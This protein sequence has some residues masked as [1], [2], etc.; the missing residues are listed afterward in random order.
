MYR[1]ELFVVAQTRLFKYFTQSL[2]F[3]LFLV[4]IH[5][6][7][8][9]HVQQPVY[10]G[11]IGLHLIVQLRIESKKLNALFTATTPAILGSIWIQHLCIK[12]TV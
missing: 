1:Y 2:H 10:V 11:F 3:C 6:N 5:S 8:P 7:G 12:S 4:H 9:Q